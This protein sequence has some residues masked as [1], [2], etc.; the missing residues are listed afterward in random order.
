MKRGHLMPKWIAVLVATTFFSEQLVFA[1]PDGISTFISQ[2]GT[3]K[4][5]FNLPSSIAHISESFQAKGGDKTIYLIQDAHTNTSGQR[6]LAK[7]IDQILASED[8][9]YVFTEAGNEDDS[10]SFLKKYGTKKQREEVGLSFLRKNKIKGTE[11]LSFTSEHDFILWGVEDREL[12][13]ASLDSYAQ[14][15][16]ASAKAKQYLSKVSR[17]LKTLKSKL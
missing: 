2:P 12:Y 13:E 6:N 7:A 17:T 4:V 5:G 3:L 14:V 11:F 15:V 16:E 10:L 9:Q 8:I 1:A